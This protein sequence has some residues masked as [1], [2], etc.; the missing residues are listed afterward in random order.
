MLK[1]APSPVALSSGSESPSNDSPLSDD[2]DGMSLGKLF[3]KDKSNTIETKYNLDGDDSLINKPSKQKS[4][5]KK[6][7]VEH[8]LGGKRKRESQP[9]N[10]GMLFKIC[11]SIL[12]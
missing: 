1:Q 11:Y 9:E 5:A 2:E 8:T 4:P 7:R 10:E 3:S 6:A 12:F